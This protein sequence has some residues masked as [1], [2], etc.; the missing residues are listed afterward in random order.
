[1]DLAFFDRTSRGRLIVTG[2]DRKDLLHRLCTNDVLGLRPGQ[3]RPACF[4]TNKGRLID[5]VA[6]LD[7][8]DDLLVLSGNPERLSGHIQEYTISEDVTVRNYMAI[9]L[10]VCG[11]AAAR[12]LG[13]Q[14]EPWRHE[15]ARLGEVT[16]TVVRVEPWLGDGY[17]VLAPDAVAL[18]RMLATH[19]TMLQGAQVEELRVRCGIPAYPNEINEERNPWE[20]RLHESIALQK[21][22]YVGQ[23]VIARLRTYSKVQNALVRLRLKDPLLPGAPLLKEGAP[24]G[25]VTSAAGE[26]ALGYV[27]SE[28]AAAGTELDGAVVYQ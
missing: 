28:F 6:I 12:V 4:C 24:V 27:R 3:A 7:R 8:G 14:L 11:P 1:M 26:L 10:L 20:A 5:W 13:V 23:E 15:K 22:C 2:R 21:G 16:V 19:G 17:I 18:R 25:E 9:E